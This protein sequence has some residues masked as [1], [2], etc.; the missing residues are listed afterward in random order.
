MTRPTDHVGAEA[1]DS[2]D[3]GKPSLRKVS[4]IDPGFRE[5]TESSVL[6]PRI[7]G[8]KKPSDPHDLRNLKFLGLAF[9]VAVVIFGI[10]QYKQSSETAREAK[11]V[12]V[13]STGSK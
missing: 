3:P 13:E 10:L 12:H 2:A 5:E 8:M 7:L 1:N 4:M 9:L 6:R 11:S